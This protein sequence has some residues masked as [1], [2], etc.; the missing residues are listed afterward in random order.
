MAKLVMIF[1]RGDRMLPVNC[2]GIHTH[3]I[4]AKVNDMVLC[5]RIMKWFS[6]YREQAGGQPKRGCVE[7]IATLS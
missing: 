3:N 1:K 5:S 7:H 2:R 6:P 4:I